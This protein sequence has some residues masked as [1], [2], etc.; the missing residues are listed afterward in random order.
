MPKQD[1]IDK[2]KRKAESLDYEL[3]S[4][5]WLLYFAVFFLLFAIL[6]MWNVA[7]V[8]D[9]LIASAEGQQQIY[10]EMSILQQQI[11]S[12]RRDLMDAK[13]SG[14]IRATSPSETPKVN[15]INPPMPSVSLPRTRPEAFDAV[16][17][18]SR[19]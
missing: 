16:K 4:H 7:D 19:P 3:D 8:R 1:I 12:L 6:T 10:K 15:N 13:I 5:R 17:Q 11:T 14:S 18:K 2:I 9:G